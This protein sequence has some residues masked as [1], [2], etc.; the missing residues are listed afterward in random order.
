[1]DCFLLER[2]KNFGGKIVLLVN[3]FSRI[4]YV[5]SNEIIGMKTLA[6]RVKQ[7]NYNAA[8]LANYLQS[9]SQVKKVIKYLNR[10]KNK[11]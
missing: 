4:F 6:L 8:Q 7:Q 10:L 5:I 2:G 3:T 9:H 11:K 1:M